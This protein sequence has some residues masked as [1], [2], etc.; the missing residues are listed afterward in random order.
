MFTERILK[1]RTH[2]RQKKYIFSFSAAATR[3]GTSVISGDR[4]IRGRFLEW[5]PDLKPS[6]RICRHS[7]SVTSA[8]S[9]LDKTSKTWI[10]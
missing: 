7:L 10:V 6:E 1:L 4:R 3:P 2:Q 8:L 9:N 5:V